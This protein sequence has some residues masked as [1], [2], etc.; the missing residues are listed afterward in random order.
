MALPPSIL[1]VCVALAWTCALGACKNANYCP[2]A[3]PNDNC[4]ERDARVTRCASSAECSAPTAACEIG[5]M[6]CVQC[7]A[8]EAGACTGTTPICGDDHACRGCTAHA[9]CDSRACLPDGSCGDDASVAYVNPAGTD[10]P[11][12]TQAAPCTRVAGALG[13][14]RPYVKLAGTTDEAVI[15]DNG[16][17]V[18][19]LAAPAAKLTRTSSAGAI[20]TVRDDGT[21]LTIHDLAIGDAPNGTSGI[22][23]VVPPG[24][25]APAVTL[26]GVKVTSNPGGGISVNSGTLTVTRSLIARNTGG[27]ISISGARFD[28][29]NSIIVKNGS[30][31]SLFGGVR[32]DG[33]VGIGMR[34]FA[35]NTIAQNEN[36]ANTGISPGVLCSAVAAPLL[37][38]NNIVYDNGA[39]PQVEGANCSWSYSDIGPMAVPVPGPGNLDAAPRFVDTVHD[40]FHLQ[41][42][43]PAQDAADPEASV[44]TDFD[45]DPRP[46]GPA[47]DIGADELRP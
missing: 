23:L 36:Q 25:G 7:T 6:T 27:G 44:A 12:C 8:A 32:V 28:I 42:G 38:G 10:N 19:F 1:S 20:V 16:R 9:D 41:A 13:T 37:F 22:G 29:T 18:V 45:G 15:V 46:Q 3:N 5:S 4:S 35:F 21:T 33:I 11:S 31:G 43:S 40:D 47:R 39:G 30:P 14:G 17:D 26:V 34:R 24:A 2:G